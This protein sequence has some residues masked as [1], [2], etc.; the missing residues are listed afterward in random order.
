MQIENKK[1]VIEKHPTQPKKDTMY[2]KYKKHLTKHDKQEQPH[3]GT[4]DNA[5]PAFI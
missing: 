5:I 3:T 4:T 1:F 2:I